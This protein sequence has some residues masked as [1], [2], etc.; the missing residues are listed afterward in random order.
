MQRN[1]IKE[2]KNV[3]EVKKLSYVKSHIL[4]TGQR[5]LE[6]EK[7]VKKKE[8]MTDY[9]LKLLE[10]RRKYSWKDRNKHKQKH[11]EMRTEI[12]DTKEEWIKKSTEK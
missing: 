9:I 5:D 6:P 12:Q 7:L 10:E 11:K 2:T 8:W 1:R 3:E 4:M